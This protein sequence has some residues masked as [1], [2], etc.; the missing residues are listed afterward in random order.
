YPGLTV[1]P[2]REDFTQAIELPSPAAER[3]VVG[4]FPGSTIGNFTPGEAR[5]FLRSARHLLGPGAAFFVG[6]DLAKDEATLVA[7][8]DDAQGVT[9]AFNKNL[10]ARINRELHGDFDLDAFQ[11]RAVWNPEESRIEM[12][13]VSLREQ[14]V[15]VAGREFR[16]A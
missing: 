16:F 1:A 11:H 13:L 7:A 9:A 6:I 10:L 15:R 8:Y 5:A 2:L 4:F 12:H 14:K 3:S